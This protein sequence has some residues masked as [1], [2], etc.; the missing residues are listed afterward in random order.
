MSRV[1]RLPLLLAALAVLCWA[2]MASAASHGHRR[3]P[4]CAVP[5][6]WQTVARDAAAVV[7]TSKT[8]REY[9]GGEDVM[10]QEWRYC[11]RAKGGFHRLVSV[12]TSGDRTPASAGPPGAL[13]SM[14]LAGRYAGW[15]AEWDYHGAYLDLQ[16]QRRNLVTGALTT[17]DLGDA[18]GAGL[19]APVPSVSLLLAPT[20]VAVWQ[21]DGCTLSP[22]LGRNDG[23]VSAI[24][25]ADPASGAA[26]T[27]DSAGGSGALANLHLDQCVAGCLPLGSTIAWWTHDGSWR[28][29]PLS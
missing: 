13:Y 16:V 27:L 20:G 25:T 22:G 17:T 24:Q 28:M 10:L 5:K 19:C 9:N 8:R 21:E 11:L 3:Q 18:A 23:P 29:A 2:P 14:V 15:V 12:G 4:P 1:R 6:G 7:I 26:K